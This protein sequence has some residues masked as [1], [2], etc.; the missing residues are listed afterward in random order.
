MLYKP[1]NGDPPR[2][3]EHGLALSVSVRH[4]RGR[5]LKGGDAALNAKSRSKSDPRAR[6][7][8][9]WDL[10]RA[11]QQQVAAAQQI[12]HKLPMRLPRLDAEARSVSGASQAARTPGASGATQMR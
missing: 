4:L 7:T 8:P 3:M 10:V 5:L 11:R 6:T 9:P 2:L 12:Q 1:L